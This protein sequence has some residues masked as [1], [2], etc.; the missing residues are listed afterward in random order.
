VF[1]LGRLKPYLHVA[2][3]TGG[4]KYSAYYAKNLIIG[5]KSFIVSA[6]RANVIKLIVTDTLFK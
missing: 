6:P 5:M 3:V 4:D 2:Q 1:H